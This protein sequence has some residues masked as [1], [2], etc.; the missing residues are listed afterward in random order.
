VRTQAPL[1]FDSPAHVLHLFSQIPPHPN[2]TAPL[3]TWVGADGKRVV[4][5]PWDEERGFP[6][7]Q[8]AKQREGA[9]TPSTAA[10]A[11]RDI[12]SGLAHVHAHGILHR[13][14]KPANVFVTVDGTCMLGE[15]HSA[16]QESYTSRKF[17]GSP[18]WMA[19]EVLSESQPA[20]RASDVFSLGVMLY[21]IACGRSTGIVH[22]YVPAG[23]EVRT[24]QELG[25]FLM[26][27]RLQMGRLRDLD[28][29]LKPILMRT[30]DRDPAVRPTATTVAAVLT[31]ALEAPDM[32]PGSSA[33]LAD[34]R[35][36]AV[37]ARDAAAA[38]Q[39]D[40]TAAQAQATEAR[41]SAETADRRAA[42]AER[43]AA[44]ARDAATAAQRDKTAAQAQAT[45]ARRSAETA[46]R[47]AAE[48][49]RVA[50]ATRA[51]LARMR[52]L[53]AAASST[54]ASPGGGGM[55]A[56]DANE[57]RLARSLFTTITAAV[58]VRVDDVVF[59][60]KRGSR[61]RLGGGKFGDVYTASM[62]GMR[63]VVKCPRPPKGADVLTAKQVMDFWCEVA[64]QR[65]LDHPHIVAVQGGYSVPDRDRPGVIE[66]AGMVMERCEGGTLEDA[67]H[68]VLEDGVVV[69]APRVCLSAHRLRWAAQT[70]SALAYLHARDLIHADLKAENVLLSDTDP[71]AAAAK[72]SDFGMSKFRADGAST[73]ESLLGIRG[74]LAYMD[75]RLMSNDGSGGDSGSLRKVSDVYSAGVLLW[76]LV[77][78]RRPHDTIVY[79]PDSRATADQQLAYFVRYVR[80]GGRPA[81]PDQLAALTPAGIGGLIGRMWAVKAED[82]PTMAAALAE[83]CSLTG[84][85]LPPAGA[86]VGAAGGAGAR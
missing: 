33:E 20:S 72:L 6:E 28:P 53:A 57:L 65:L 24:I 86:G 39:R 13:D 34:A 75:P 21:Q 50:A 70:L 85:P 56:A 84:L 9:W 62:H 8:E 11:C 67:L 31:L 79:P 77:T 54:P 26:Y 14:V 1:E 55:S 61:V 51:E 27:G 83:L 73:K 82:R 30:L 81:S 16:A 4:I 78:V 36:E 35:R 58:S 64:V 46:D 22:P 37:A 59:E 45:E 69:K 44:A 48:A 10:R 43:V 38:A 66:E 15:L 74:S 76:E 71:G 5:T 60:S 32:L 29:R 80:E 40:K 3:D 52:E 41:R 12:A 47:R 19:P 7:W 18:L 17:T 23:E 49:D 63:R 2:V 25:N 68:G 42:E